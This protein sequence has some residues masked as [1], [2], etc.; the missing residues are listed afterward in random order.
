MWTSEGFANGIARNAHLS[1]SSIS[2]LGNKALTNMKYAMGNAMR[3]LDEE[4]SVSPTITPVLDLSKFKSDA[5]S[6]N[7]LFSDQSTMAAYSS[8]QASAIENERSQAEG[9]D[10]AVTDKSGVILNFTQNNTSPKA[11]DTIDTY[12]NTKNQIS[13]V[14]GMVDS[15]NAYADKKRR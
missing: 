1:D 5:S 4:T 15:A 7:G 2:K 9:D 8:Q 10:D 11:I 12:R 3:V 6:M 14:K 13:S